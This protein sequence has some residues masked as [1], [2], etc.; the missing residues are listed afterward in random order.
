MV[1]GSPSISSKFKF[2]L[3][4]TTSQTKKKQ[5]EGWTGDLSDV[6]SL[7][8]SGEKAEKLSCCTRKL[9]I[10]ADMTDGGYSHLTKAS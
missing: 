9:G 7:K 10:K 3:S 4:T 2:K 1:W 5:I 6:Y 8:F